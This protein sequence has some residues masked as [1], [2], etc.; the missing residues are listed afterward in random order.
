MSASSSEYLLRTLGEY[1]GIDNGGGSHVAA[2]PWDCVVRGNGSTLQVLLPLTASAR[3]ASLA[4]IAAAR[5]TT[6]SLFEIQFTGA[7]LGDQPLECVRILV[8]VSAL[9][10]ASLAAR[11]ETGGTSGT[12]SASASSASGAATSLLSTAAATVAAT[13]PPA[14]DLPLRSCVF[15][16]TAPHLI[17][18]P[19]EWFAAYART[20]YQ[21]S[22]PPY[23]FDSGNC[24]HLGLALQ[25][26]AAVRAAP[27]PSFVVAVL[28]ETAPVSEQNAARLDVRARALRQ[29]ALDYKAA[30]QTH[31][32]HVF[33]L[34]ARVMRS[35]ER[36][37]AFRRMLQVSAT[38][39]SIDP[40]SN[41][42]QVSGA[43]A[44]AH[45]HL[46]VMAH[47]VTVPCP[48]PLRAMQGSLEDRMAALGV[49]LIVQ[50]PAELGGSD[51]PR[52]ALQDRIPDSESN[53]VIVG[54][55]MNKLTDVVHSEVFLA[56]IEGRIVERVAHADFHGTRADATLSSSSSSSS[57]A[58]ASFSSSSPVDREITLHLHA[59]W[60]GFSPFVAH[61]TVARF[62]LLD[63]ERELFESGVSNE[64][65]DMVWEEV[66]FENRALDF[67]HFSC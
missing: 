32:S 3:A 28:A 66:R 63:P 6:N 62:A 13:A 19:M 4:L 48:P 23:R 60:D 35:N 26:H 36:A 34:A 41:R 10:R 30:L 43:A 17:A 65:L 49:S 27:L 53:Y 42:L 7:D 56:L 45:R 20:F 37:E 67:R 29:G 5:H 50:Q 15:C 11:A 52:Y 31:L 21:H 14:E 47:G 8:S 57:S 54:A 59:S 46:A 25:W 39:V 24:Q 44:N 1:T 64:L 61:W 55:A 12:A 22:R 9:L 33:A 51:A 2:P 38:S 40:H 58:S 18:L 16:L